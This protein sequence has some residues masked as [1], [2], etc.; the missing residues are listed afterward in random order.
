MLKFALS[1]KT[2][3][4]APVYSQLQRMFLMHA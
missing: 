2:Q 3:S 1:P 4:T